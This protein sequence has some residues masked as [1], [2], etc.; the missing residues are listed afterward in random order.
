MFTT[1]KNLFGEKVY[2]TLREIFGAKRLLI[3][4]HH[5]FMEKMENN[6]SSS[7]VQVQ[8]ALCAA[9]ATGV[10]AAPHAEAALVNTFANTVI[11]IPATTAGIYLNLETGV[12][13]T[14][15]GAA[16][17]YDFNPYLAGGGTQLGFYWGPTATR[18]AGVASTAA[19]GPY[20]DLAVGTVVGAASTFTS[21]ITATT[22]SPYLA[23][24]THILGFSF[25]NAAGTVDY[26][27]LRIQ[28]TAANGFPA[29]ILG[30]VYNNTPG[31]AVTVAAAPEPSTVA[32]LALAGGAVGVRAWRRRK[33]A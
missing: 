1:K 20:L 15:A 14:A 22:G 10:V 8:L 2:H 9:A 18:G 30:W 29:T 24:G 7:K 17:G 12:N 28:T 32:F 27:Y 21:G 3:T 31:T 4:K 25:F 33:T 11:S 26:G 19:N 13:G 5:L 23:T 6:L 16:V